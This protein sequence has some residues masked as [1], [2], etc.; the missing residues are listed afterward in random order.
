VNLHCNAYIQETKFE[1]T[2]GLLGATMKKLGIV[3]KAGGKKIQCL[4]TINSND[5]FFFRS[6]RTLLLGPFLLLCIPHHLLPDA[7]TD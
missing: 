3:S 6:E 1:T 4:V 7:L 2:R 5:S